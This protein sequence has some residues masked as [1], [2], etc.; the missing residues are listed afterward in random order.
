MYGSLTNPIFYIFVGLTCF[1]TASIYDRI[2]RIKRDNATMEN[3]RRNFQSMEAAMNRPKHK[4]DR[5][6]MG[7]DYCVND[8]Y[9]YA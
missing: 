5:V 1:C 7:D 8:S 6:I 3:L 4:D 2:I 9:V